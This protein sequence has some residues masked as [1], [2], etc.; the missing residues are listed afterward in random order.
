MAKGDGLPPRFSLA[1][2]LASAY[3]KRLSVTNFSSENNLPTFR[4]NAPIIFRAKS[5]EVKTNIAIHSHA[6]LRI[7]I[8]RRSK[9]VRI[10]PP[11][12]PPHHSNPAT[13]NFQFSIPVE[14]LLWGWHL[15][16]LGLNQSICISTWRGQ[17]TAPNQRL[18]EVN[19]KL[20]AFRSA[21]APDYSIWFWTWHQT[22]CGAELSNHWFQ[23]LLLSFLSSFD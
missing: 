6:L 3:M 21:W 4:L 2:Q 7:H 10:A 19:K 5:E 14:V 1:S 16:L 13:R 11:S 20:I 8:H 17:D 12:L 15:V 22:G 18:L 9:V 23:G